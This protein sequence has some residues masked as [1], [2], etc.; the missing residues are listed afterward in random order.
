MNFTKNMMIKLIRQASDRQ[1]LKPKRIP[2][3]RGRMFT[4]SVALAEPVGMPIG[5]NTGGNFGRS[6]ENPGLAEPPILTKR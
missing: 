6:S 1:Q 4:G 2:E 3:R 5:K